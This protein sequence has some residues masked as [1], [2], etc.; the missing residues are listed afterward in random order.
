MYGRGACGAVMIP[1]I[2]AC[3]TYKGHLWKFLTFY[4]IYVTLDAIY[5]SGVYLRFFLY[6]PSYLRS[7]ANID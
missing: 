5:D 3:G 7:I 1:Y 2:Y 6:G 4:V